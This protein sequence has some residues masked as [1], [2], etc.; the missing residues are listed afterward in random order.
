MNELKLRLA[1]YSGQH[2][3]AGARALA[4]R[5]GRKDHLHRRAI[6]ASPCSCR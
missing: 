1:P 6:K 2:A 3:A 4:R 5:L